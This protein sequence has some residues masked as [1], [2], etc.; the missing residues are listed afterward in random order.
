[1][2]TCLFPA[3]WEK[4][5]EF[6][7]M[8]GDAKLELAKNDQISIAWMGISLLKE[9]GSYAFLAGT[10]ANHDHG[11]ESMRARRDLGPLEEGGSEA[12]VIPGVLS[13]GSSL[14][15]S[16]LI[17]VPVSFYNRFLRDDLFQAGRAEM[18]EERQAEAPCE[19]AW[20]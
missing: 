6:G 2:P 10:S 18:S 19:S 3:N 9:Q 8:Q 5:G 16:P 4:Q 7:E 20:T 11:S 15:N 1:M 12:L 13:L 14:C 17:F